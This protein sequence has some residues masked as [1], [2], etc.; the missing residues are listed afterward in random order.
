ML[1]SV[2][3]RWAGVRADV[4]AFPPGQVEAPDELQV[5]GMAVVEHGKAHDVGLVVHHVIQPEQREVL[6]TERERE[7]EEKGKSY[8]LAVSCDVC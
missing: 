8:L 7:R 6:Q 3:H 2:S 1:I 4:A 5:E